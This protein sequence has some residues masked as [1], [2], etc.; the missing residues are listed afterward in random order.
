VGQWMTDLLEQDSEY[1][2]LIKAT[3]QSIPDPHF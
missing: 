3:H 2:S 1:V